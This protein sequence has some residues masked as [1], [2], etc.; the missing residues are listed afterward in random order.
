M[1]TDSHCKQRGSPDWLASRGSLRSSAVGLR[2]LYRRGSAN[3]SPLPVPPAQTGE[4][5]ESGGTGRGR[6][7]REDG[8]SKHR[9][10]VR[11]AANPST[12]AGG[13]FHAV[14]HG[15]TVLSER[16]QHGSNC[17]ELFR[18]DYY[19]SEKRRVSGSISPVKFNFLSESKFSSTSGETV[20]VTVSSVGTINPTAS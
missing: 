11:S 15:G 10:E 12:G 4:A 20:F 17:V 9:N 1:R 19:S 5:A 6:R 2:C 3:R 13:G 16:Y 7:L 18:L 14:S 8:R